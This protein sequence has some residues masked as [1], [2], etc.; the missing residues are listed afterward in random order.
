MTHTSAHNFMS[1]Y[2]FTRFTG[3]GYFGMAWRNAAH[4]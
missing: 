1:Y 4:E 3:Y 2:G